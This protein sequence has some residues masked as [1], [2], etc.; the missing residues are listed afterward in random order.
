[1]RK[2]QLPLSELS[3]WSKLGLALTASLVALAAMHGM[4]TT[5]PRTAAQ[6]DSAR[7]P[8][9]RSCTRSPPG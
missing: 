9:S 2:Y 7:S 6:R 5:L 1:M 4:L 3:D 8:R